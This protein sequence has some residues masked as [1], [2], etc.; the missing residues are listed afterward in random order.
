MSSSILEHITD[1]AILIETIIAAV[2]IEK[3]PEEQPKTARTSR[4]ITK[5]E[6]NTFIPPH[7]AHNNSCGNSPINLDINWLQTLRY[8]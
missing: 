3:R 7:K 5:I 4:R 2:S 1:T 6:L 8:K